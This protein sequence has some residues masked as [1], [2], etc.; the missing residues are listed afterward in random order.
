MR[1]LQL[2]Y[3]FLRVLSKLDILKNL[4]QPWFK[5][6]CSSHSLSVSLSHSSSLTLALYLALPVSL[7]LYT[8]F[9]TTNALPHHFVSVSPGQAS[10]IKIRNIL[11][12]S[13]EKS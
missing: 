4:K 12:S 10:I 9:T 7:Y 5:R 6:V 1:K 3:I 2:E 8:R 11:Q 13:D